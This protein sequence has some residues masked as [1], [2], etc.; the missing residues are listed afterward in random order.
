M[1]DWCKV[2]EI[3]EASFKAMLI[4][5]KEKIPLET[6]LIVSQKKFE[7]YTNPMPRDREKSCLADAVKKHG[8]CVD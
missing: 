3:D 2:I 5:E 1:Q 8:I 6:H 4:A 7:L